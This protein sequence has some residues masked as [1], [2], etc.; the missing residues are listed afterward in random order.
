MAASQK[1]HMIS[2]KYFICINQEYNVIY[3]QNM[4]FVHSILWPGGVYIDATHATKAK[5]TIPYSDEIMNQ[6]QMSQINC[7]LRW[8]L[9]LQITPWEGYHERNI[10]MLLY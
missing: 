10:T 6:C 9:L 4:K 8:E 3:L 1:V 7:G 2:T 5:I